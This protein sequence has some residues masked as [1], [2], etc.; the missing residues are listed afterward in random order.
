ME[1]SEPELTQLGFYIF[2]KLE[3]LE[4]SKEE[5]VYNQNYSKIVRCIYHI[6][7][8]SELAYFSLKASN[9]FKLIMLWNNSDFLCLEC[10]IVF[11]VKNHLLTLCHRR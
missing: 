11:I 5:W 3:N 8:V 1:A 7:Q 4:A 9:Y 6:I 10:Q 2:L